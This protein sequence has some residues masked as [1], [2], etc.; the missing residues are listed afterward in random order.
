VRYYA[1]DLDTETLSAGLENGD[2]TKA[3]RVYVLGSFQDKP[4]ERAAVRK[5]LE[6]LATDRRLVV[7]FNRPQVKV[8]AYQ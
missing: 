1:P 8:W 2:V 5:G 3:R 6:R 7:R 4:A